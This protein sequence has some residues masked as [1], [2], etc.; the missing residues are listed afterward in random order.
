MLVIEYIMHSLIVWLK[1]IFDKKRIL[2]LDWLILPK[3]FH[4]TFIKRIINFVFIQGF[5]DIIL[6]INILNNEW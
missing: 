1:Y 5:Y 3:E 2:D 6:I 4:E